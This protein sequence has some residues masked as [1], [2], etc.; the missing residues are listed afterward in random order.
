MHSPLPAALRHGRL[1]A[2]V[3][4]TAMTNGLAIFLV[5]CI[6]GFLALDASLFDWDLSLSLAR[7]FAGLL[8]WMAFWR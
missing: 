4:R 5:I 2:V 7:R 8:S 6:A 1:A 3:T